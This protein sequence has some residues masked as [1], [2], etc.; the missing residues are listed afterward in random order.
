MEQP[1][2]YDVVIL[3]MDFPKYSRVATQL[4]MPLIR[5]RDEK[6]KFIDIKKE[7]NQGKACCYN[8]LFKASRVSRL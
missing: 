5:P 8:K 4:Y 6:G 1:W 2:V 7:T 3:I